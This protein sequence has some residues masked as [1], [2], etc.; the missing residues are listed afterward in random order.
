MSTFLPRFATRLRPGTLAAMV[1]LLQLG[2]CAWIR[3]DP[4]QVAMIN[5]QQAQLSQVIHLASDQWPDSRWWLKY[6]DP[7]LTALINQAL[8]NSPT[9]QAAR[10]RVEQSQA[11][12]D[13][14]HSFS[15]VQATA[16]AAQNR[17]RTTDRSF[18]WPYSFSLPQ[19]RTGPWYTMNTVGV[20]GTLNLDL[21]GENRERVAAALGEKN[22]Q[23]AE[24]AMTEQTVAA[25][26]ARLYFSVQAAWQRIALL[27]QQLDIS[28]FSLAAHQARVGRGLEDD[29]ALAAAQSE[30]LSA[31]QQLLSARTDLTSAREMLRALVGAGP[32]GLPV[33]TPQ[34][35]PQVQETLPASLSYGLLSRRP[36]LQAMRG[37]VL[38]SLSRVDAAKSAFYPHLDI[39]AFWG[40]NAFSVGDLF[41]YSF[42]QINVLPG[43]YLPLFDGGRLNANLKTARTSSNILIKNY[44]QAVLDAVRDVAVSSQQLNALDQQVGLQQQKVVAAQTAA[45]SAQAHYQRGLMSRY[46]SREARRAVLAQQLVL[47]DLKFQQISTDISLIQALGG[48]YQSPLQAVPVTD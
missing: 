9:I 14:A 47:T 7:Q 3:H 39:K 29:V 4:G 10:L 48:G 5:P 45:D 37:Y 46:A 44:N 2:G 8:Q 41:K 23:L 28:R 24:T 18:T 19:D 21:W 12:V 11:G 40:Y 1:L 25:N 38:A 6:Q 15:G 36:D 42:Q 27:Q 16:V 35:W 43:L 34:P 20:A 30:S 13:L 26:V 32:H 22:A 17:L 33:I 31:E